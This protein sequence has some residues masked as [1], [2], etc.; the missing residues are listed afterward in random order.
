MSIRV[1]RGPALLVR[2]FL[3]YEDSV[4]TTERLCLRK[5]K[6]SDLALFAAMNADPRVMERIGMTHS[7]A[8]D[9]EHPGLRIDH[10]L[11]SH[12]L[13]RMRPPSPKS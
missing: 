5:W 3:A 6:D 10:P 9:F 12:V 4:L 13:Y 1:S 7:P 2:R 11:R 8:D